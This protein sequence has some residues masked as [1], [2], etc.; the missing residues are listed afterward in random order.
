MKNH[1][2][3]GTAYLN[4][5]INRHGIRPVLL[6]QRAGWKGNLISQLRSGKRLISPE[7]AVR[8]EA[9]SDG[10][11]QADRSCPWFFNKLKSLGF[12]RLKQGATD[13]AQTNGKEASDTSDPGDHPGTRPS[14]SAVADTGTQPASVRQPAAD[15]GHHAVP[16][17]A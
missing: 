9:A 12:I 14:G 13:E 11:I 7:Q 1:D 6:N 10:L 2:A 15:S 3:N 4:E 5:I 17:T 8:L 16:G